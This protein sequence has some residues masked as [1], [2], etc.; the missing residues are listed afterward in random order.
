MNTYSGLD[1]HKGSVFVCI[2]NEKNFRKAFR[3]INSIYTQI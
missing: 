3:Y 1:L 2:I